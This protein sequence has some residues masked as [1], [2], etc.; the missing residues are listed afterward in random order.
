MQSKKRSARALTLPIIM[1]LLLSACG[2]KISQ[3]NFNKIKDGMAEADVVNILGEPT[4]SSSMGVAGL[5]GSSS[6]WK[7]DKTSIT[8]QFVNGKVALKN[9][10]KN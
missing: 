4:E 9:F 7:K 2:S 6:T 3:E 5:S 8:I 10:T 1:A